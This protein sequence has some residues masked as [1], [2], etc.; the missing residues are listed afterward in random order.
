[1]RKPPLGREFATGIKERLLPTN[2]VF[3]ERK[4]SRSCSSLQGRP[5][6][7]LQART[8]S[9]PCFSFLR[10]ITLRHRL[11]RRNRHSPCL[12]ENL[13]NGPPVGYAEYHP[14]AFLRLPLVWYF[15]LSQ[16]ARLSKALD[17]INAKYGRGTIFHLYEGIS[18]P[19]QMRRDMLTPNYTTSWSQIP[20]VK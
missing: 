5:F 14:M 9:T 6:F 15:R 13:T 12:P 1:M 18:K 20:V 17:K 2:C 16:D 7:C 11:V 10:Q 8:D 3:F 19:W 4:E